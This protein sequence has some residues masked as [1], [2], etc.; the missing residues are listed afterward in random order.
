[1]INLQKLSV[2]RPTDGV[3]SGMLK[4]HS[5]SVLAAMGLC[6][7]LASCAE[8]PV[9]QDAG[10]CLDPNTPPDRAIEE[11]TRLI[12]SRQGETSFLTSAYFARAYA[13]ERKQDIDRALSDYGE[14]I[15][16]DPL[17]FNAYYNRGS[18][19]K[20]YK[21]DFARAIT[22]LDE[23][24]RL[25][26]RFANTYIN[27]GVAHHLSGHHEQAISDYSAALR[28]SPNHSLA[29]YNRGIVYFSLGK[30]A[31]AAEDEKIALE[32]VS[33]PFDGYAMLLRY[34][35]RVRSG[36]SSLVGAAQKELT[37]SS[38]KGG[39]RGWPFPIIDFYLGRSDEQALRSHI[40]DANPRQRVW[41]CDIDFHLAEWYLLTGAT[42]RATSLLRAVTADCPSSDDNYWA[43]RNELQR[44]MQG[45]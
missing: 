1:M 42:T 9:R 15:R 21:H 5:V 12:Q 18:L 30:F 8:A 27:R 17:D 41:S 22:D 36:E 35:A 19:L 33:A 37:E 26:P 23:A 11:C 24:I 13:W 45:R 31:Q 6:A 3:G 29:H 40:R 44:I 38:A 39:N 2:G 34:L 10:A 25:N 32:R 43:A 28:V 7:V 4:Q 16:L 14:V 20:G